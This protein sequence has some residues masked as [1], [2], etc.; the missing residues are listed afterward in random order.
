VNWARVAFIAIAIITLFTV[1]RDV[2]AS[3]QNSVVQGL[4]VAA[5]YALFYIA[6]IILLLPDVHR[7]FT[8]GENG[9]S[10]VA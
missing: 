4:L 6:A 2:P 3:F 5:C 1:A 7:W 10:R 9:A 8:K